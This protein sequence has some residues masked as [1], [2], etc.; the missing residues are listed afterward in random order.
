MKIG[1][2]KVGLW[3]G[4]L[5]GI[6]IILLPHPEGMSLLAWRTVGSGVWTVSY[7][8]LTLPTKA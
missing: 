5:I 4:P 1:Y 2:Q 8:H 3:M 7:T 6:T